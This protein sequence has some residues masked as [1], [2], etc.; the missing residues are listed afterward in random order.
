MKLAK[1]KLK[2][3]IRR[4]GP[5]FLNE[6]LLIHS[7]WGLK[8]GEI[9]IL[10]KNHGYSVLALS[11]PGDELLSWLLTYLL[12]R[13][14]AFASHHCCLP[15]QPVRF[16]GEHCLLTSADKLLRHSRALGCT[17]AFKLPKNH[18]H[19]TGVYLQGSINAVSRHFTIFNV[20]ILAMP[21]M[22]RTTNLLIPQ[23]VE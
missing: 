21:Q 6:Q 19:F 11:D 23:I 18:H 2:L 4:S 16:Q 10:F 17:A 3:E 8:C 15:L 1:N 13:I 7:T 12:C 22:Q 9:Q 20:F 5:S 14:T